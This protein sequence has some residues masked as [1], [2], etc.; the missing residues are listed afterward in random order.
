LGFYERECRDN[1]KFGGTLAPLAP[2]EWGART[3]EQFF[4][5]ALAMLAPPNCSM[6]P[7]P[8]LRPGF[9]SLAPLRRFE[10]FGF[11]AAWGGGLSRAPLSIFSNPQRQYAQE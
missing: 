2:A 8:G 4:G 9:A 5:R 3:I 7:T 11:S 10:A 1:N 6:K